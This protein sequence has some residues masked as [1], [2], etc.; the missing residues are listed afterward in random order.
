MTTWTADELQRIGDAEELGV[1]SVR[2][3]GTL[4]SYVT[5]WMVRVGDD[6]YIRSM[7][8]EGTPW[9]RRA[10]ASGVGRVRAGGV[11]RDVTFGEVDPDVH[12]DI[13]AAF[14]TKY[15]RFGPGPV[16]AVVGPTAHPVTFRLIPRD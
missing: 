13:D 11:E 4:R 7:T 14:H 15:D 5:I 1:A 12:G 16:G 3:D 8:S 6:I 2:A 9:Y 10:K